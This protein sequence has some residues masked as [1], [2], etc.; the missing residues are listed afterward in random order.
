MW[1]E[2]GFSGGFEKEAVLC[3][4]AAATCTTRETAQGRKLREGKVL[5]LGKVDIRNFAIVQ[6]DC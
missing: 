6:P 2:A 4:V 3:I 5:L 1:F